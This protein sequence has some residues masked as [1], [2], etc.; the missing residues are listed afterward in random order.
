M[1]CSEVITFLESKGSPENI[2][3]MARF[4]ISSNGTL[5][6]SVPVV[7]ELAKKLKKNHS[8]A[9]ELWE[10]EIHE[11]RLL[12]GFIADPKKMTE[13]EMESWVVGFDSWDICDQVCTNC[14][15]Y[16]PWAF[17]KA[18]EWCHREEEFVRRAGFVIQVGISVHLK[19]V[20]DERLLPFF[21]LMVTYSD[22]NRNF[23]KKAI[24]WSL[25]TLGKRSAFLFA[26][27]VHIAAELK[28]ME[29]PSAR[30]IGSDAFRE[31][32]EKEQNGTL[33]FLRLRV[34][35]R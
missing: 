25:R 7:R 18:E 8:L 11:A 2:A 12:A 21:D 1:T 35:G 28:T 26:T 6:V 23:V 5:G 29:S 9:V 4:G 14:F 3:G 30:W 27:A 20:E 16:T 10:T 32:I 31:L 13:E 15:N 17:K 19:K 33:P 22:D 34:A 24:N